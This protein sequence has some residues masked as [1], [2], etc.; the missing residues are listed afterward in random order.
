M[1]GEKDGG[2]YK[3]VALF[4][5]SVTLLNC[6]VLYCTVKCPYKSFCVSICVAI[7]VPY[8]IALLEHDKRQTMIYI[9]FICNSFL[10]IA[11]DCYNY[12]DRCRHMKMLPVRIE[13]NMGLCGLMDKAS[14]FGS[15]DCRFESCHSRRNSFF[16]T[17]S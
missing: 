14:D 1:G 11:Q 8:S 12:Q 7:F 15:E 17:E 2:Q 6:T 5:L 16:D 4:L 3:G 9:S 10:L 13:F